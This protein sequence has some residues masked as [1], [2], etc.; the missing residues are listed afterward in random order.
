M[1]KIVEISKYKIDRKRY[2][3]KYKAVLLQDEQNK[4]RKW[5]CIVLQDAITNDIV[6]FTGLEKYVLDLSCT[7]S[8]S[9][10]TY[11]I[12][13]ARVVMFLNYIL[14]DT[15]ICS[16]HE[17]T[18]NDIRNYLL[19]KRKNKYGEDIKSDS[20]GRIRKDIFVFLENYYRYNKETLPFCYNTENIREIIIVKEKNSRLSRKHVVSR[21]KALNIK[22]P[23]GNDNK[24][25]KRTIMYG[26]LKAMLYTAKKYDPMIY[27]AICLMAYAGLREG[28]VVNLSF[29]DIRK[30]SQLG[31]TN[32][33]TLE[34]RNS[35]KFRK[36]KTSTGIIKKIR[37][38]DVYPDFLDE[39][40][41]AL[42][43]HKNILEAWGLPTE[44]DNAV[45]YNKH[46]RPMSVTSLLARIKDLFV[47]Y[48]MSVLKETSENTDFEGETYAFID[49]YESE[50]P[51]AHMFRHWF[52]MYLI[53]KKKLRRELVVKW[54][55]DSPSSNAYEEYVHLNYDLI[56]AY[57]KTAYSFQESLVKDIYG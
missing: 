17:V 47:C 35:D 27:L 10:K 49:A 57:R 16:L 43:F 50:Y 19:M 11:E 23:K 38:Q 55:G 44:G 24:H 30:T 32:K 53:T 12:A 37:D 31:I 54:R 13:M 21:Y 6:E 25:R 34:L 8:L 45:F 3:F 56:E 29:S 46:R 28:E 15:S 5:F 14:N 9:E 41:N 51:G 1:E 33:I 20:W 52:T 48:F 36:G 26:H 42:E 40:E 4:P 39:V 18:I 2:E 22:P 7:D